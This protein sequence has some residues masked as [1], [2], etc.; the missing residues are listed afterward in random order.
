M[1]ETLVNQDISDSYED[2]DSGLIK[3]GIIK[4]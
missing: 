1:E 2:I 3:N 4:M